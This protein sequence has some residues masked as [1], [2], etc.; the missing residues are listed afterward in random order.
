M[1][2]FRLVGEIADAVAEQQSGQS[3]RHRGVERVDGGEG[4]RRGAQ[5]CREGRGGGEEMVM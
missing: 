1:V 5:G 2:S 4:G 3:A